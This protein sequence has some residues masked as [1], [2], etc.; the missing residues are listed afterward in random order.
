M[1]DA[2]TN[3]RPLR[4]RTADELA[5]FL[6]RACLDDPW[7]DEPGSSSRL[8][9]APDGFLYTAERLRLHEEL[10]AA[11][12][13]RTPA[14]SDDGTLAVV[15]TAGPPGA[16][17]STALARM[18][19]LDDFRHVDADDFKDALLERAAADGLLD[20]WTTRVLVDGRPVQPRELAGFVHAESTAVAD[21][22]RRRSLRDG[23]NVVVHG[24]LS[25]VDYLD[26]LLS[27]L[28]DAGYDRLKI[29][30]V[31]VPFDAALEQATERWW[32]VR[33]LGSDPLGGRFVPEA[34]IRRY[35]PD[36]TGSLC[37]SNASELER[38]ATDL[39]WHV[40]V[41]RIG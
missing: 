26:D 13:D 35:Y 31:E 38:R 6:Q 4:D 24:T 19:E 33:A 37:R 25:S 10:L 16:G 22:L 23:E 30:D 14:P 8:R 21:T 40:T 32:Q 29:V 11:H 7:S 27:E 36:G 9:Y 39:G 20:A 1:T 3:D 12:A 15:V 5:A 34:A 2:D 41:E 17:K 28:D 18:P